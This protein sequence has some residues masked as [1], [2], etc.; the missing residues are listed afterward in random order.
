[1]THTA[2][3][4]PAR[5]ASAAALAAAPVLLLTAVLQLADE[6][7][8]EST[9]VGIE[10]LTVACLS[11]LLALMIPVTLHLG[12]RA[13][14][15]RAALVPAV[16]M[17]ALAV[18]STVSNIRGSD[19]S[20]FAAVAAPANLLWFGG[21]I[22]LAVVLRRRDALPRALAIG[23]PLLWIAT[24]PGSMIGLGAV[25]AAYCLVLGRTL[26]SSSAPAPAFLIPAAR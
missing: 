21:W 17:A 8:S 6:Q 23:L 2:P 12:Q 4:I 20:F 16:G 11:V 13:G 3:R 10:H 1:M 22:G 25:G 19:P 7:S 24:I 5:T 15:P 26:S 9:T 14:A 18:L